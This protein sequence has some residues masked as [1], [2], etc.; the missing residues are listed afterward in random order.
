LI[1]VIKKK[2]KKKKSHKLDGIVVHAHILAA[3]RD[4]LDAEGDPTEAELAGD[5]HA[6]QLHVHGDDLHGAHAPLLQRRHEVAAAV[7][8]GRAGA[9]QAQPHHVR[10][11]LGLGGAR[12][13]RVHDAR[14]R[15]PLLELEHGQA[16]LGGPGAFVRIKVTLL[17]NHYNKNKLANYFQNFNSACRFLIITYYCF[18]VLFICYNSLTLSLNQII[19]FSLIVYL[20]YN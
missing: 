15:Q 16:R 14:I 19:Y 18:Y 3:E 7:G 11:V 20:I 5:V 13:A 10:H 12:G 6:A 8:K 4:L 17:I 9:P 2:E 1:I